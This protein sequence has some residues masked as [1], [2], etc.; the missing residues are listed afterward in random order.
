MH[1]LWARWL[2]AGER[3]VL[4]RWRPERPAREPDGDAF[5]LVE[6]GG[7]LAGVGATAQDAMDDYI[8]PLCDLL[9]DPEAAAR[10]FATGPW[11]SAEE[12]LLAH[13]TGVRVRRL[14][15]AGTV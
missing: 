5:Y 10:A 2:A 8:Q 9:S 12:M 14:G 3:E 13:C 6:R 7:E 11:T 1:E 15:S 4:E